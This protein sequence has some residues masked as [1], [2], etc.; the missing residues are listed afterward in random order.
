MSAELKPDLEKVKRVFESF[1][2]GRRGKERLPE[3]LWGEAIALLGQ[4]PLS[5]VCRELRL[6]PNY[7]RQRAEAVRQGNT[8]KFKLHTSL[9]KP[10]ATP[11]QEFFSLTAGQLNTVPNNTQ[12][13]QP[14][15]STIECRVMIERRDGSRLQLTVPMDWTRIEALCVG[16][17]RG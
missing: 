12:F 6:K 13:L 8:E 10:R 15:S 16:F 5:V 2:A 17:L 4:Y 14:N 7:L 3:N 1:R 9:K 11:K